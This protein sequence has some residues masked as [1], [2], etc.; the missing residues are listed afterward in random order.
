MVQQRFRAAVNLPESAGATSFLGVPPHV[1]EVLGAGQRPP[2]VVTLNGYSYR[3]TVAVYGGQFV[4]PVRRE[5]REA[6]RVTTGE[7]LDVSIELDQAPRTVDVPAGLAAALDADPAMRSRFDALSY[8]HQKEYVDWIASA[9]REETRR[10]RIE[11]AVEM[12]RA[13]TRTP[14]P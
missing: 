11:K 12:V 10:R 6:A 5:V 9:K 4:V 2:V 7:P 1:V 3:S 8:S 13:G 14:K